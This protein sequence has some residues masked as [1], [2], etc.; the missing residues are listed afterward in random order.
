MDPYTDILNVY[1]ILSQSLLQS[2]DL[3]AYVRTSII[4]PII[5]NYGKALCES[6]EKTSS[7]LG[8]QN[9]GIIGIIYTRTIS[10]ESDYQP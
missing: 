2:H 7:A 8:C 4:I 1:R 5:Y 10:S 3:T 6:L 9:A